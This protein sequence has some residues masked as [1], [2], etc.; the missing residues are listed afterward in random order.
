MTGFNY[1]F[2]EQ[3][4]GPI[5]KDVLINQPRRLR[6]GFSGPADDI[7]SMNL[8]TIE[9]VTKNCRRRPRQNSYDPADDIEI[10]DL[11]S[12]RDQI[13]PTTWHW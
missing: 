10:I 2:D 1:P 5:I 11:D 13:K 7:E 8:S 12:N 3:K 6:Q 4:R 9:N